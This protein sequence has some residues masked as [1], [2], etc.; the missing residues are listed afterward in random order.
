MILGLSSIGLVAL[1]VPLLLL[2]PALFI[3]ED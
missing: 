3:S 1:A 2:I